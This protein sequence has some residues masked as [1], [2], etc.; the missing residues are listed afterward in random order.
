MDK[1]EESQW[2]K[3]YLDHSDQIENRLTQAIDNSEARVNKSLSDLSTTL[4][5]RID[6]NGT[7]EQRRQVRCKR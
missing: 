4:N 1:S 2:V 5:A 3:L 7:G 6:S